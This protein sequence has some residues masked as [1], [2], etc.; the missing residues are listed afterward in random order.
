MASK[1][2][3]STSNKDSVA[4][5]VQSADIAREWT[6]ASAPLDPLSR[7]IVE[8]D[9]NWVSFR[10]IFEVRYLK[11]RPEPDVDTALFWKHLTRQSKFP[12]VSRQAIFNA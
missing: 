11:I 4:A 9:I 8:S 12:V 1:H 10:P 3:R 2:I 7:R 5:K 6:A